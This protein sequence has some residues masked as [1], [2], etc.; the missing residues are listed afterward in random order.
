MA[1][2]ARKQVAP[3][4]RRDP[5]RRPNDG[6]SPLARL[7]H[8]DPNKKYVWVNTNDQLAGVDYYLSIGYEVEMRREDGPKQ[9]GLGRNPFRKLQGSEESY[10]MFQGNVLMSCDRAVADDIELNGP[11]GTSGQVFW[12]TIEKRLTGRD[13]A[14][15]LLRDVPGIIGRSG[16]PIIHVENETSA[17][18]ADIG[19]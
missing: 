10:L 7:T 19:V 11:D 2:A 13:H 9:V 4:T 8:T 12:D 18:E 5:V 15:K 17:Q 6:V 1:A 16:D 3:Q 14:K